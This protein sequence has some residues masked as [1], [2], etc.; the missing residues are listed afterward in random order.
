MP[1]M[2]RALLLLLCAASVC[3]TMSDPSEEEWDNVLWDP[4]GVG[5]MVWEEQP[6]PAASNV[7]VPLIPPVNATVVEPTDFHEDF[8][9]DAVWIPAGNISLNFT[10]AENILSSEAPSSGA[11]VDMVLGQEEHVLYS[12]LNKLFDS[13]LGV[14]E[15]A[16][17]DES[18][19]FVT[20]ITLMPLRCSEVHKVVAL[21]DEAMQKSNPGA[22]ITSSAQRL[23]SAICDGTCPC[24]ESRRYSQRVMEL[25]STSK[26]RSLQPP[27]RFPYPVQIERL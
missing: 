19:A 21:F 13:L 15:N 27:A 6:L 20:F 8:S 23:G 24:K 10:H 1:D 16:T 2:V 4:T 7:S 12:K 9:E 3:G 5:G 18:W 11:L 26:R 14:P 17:A 25:R 22:D